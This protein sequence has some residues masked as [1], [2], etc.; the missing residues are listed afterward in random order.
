[1][2]STTS[3]SPL[4][5]FAIRWLFSTNHKCEALISSVRGVR[6]HYTN[7]NFLYGETVTVKFQGVF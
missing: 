2:G 3:N 7:M 1:M 6:F 5:N 4:L